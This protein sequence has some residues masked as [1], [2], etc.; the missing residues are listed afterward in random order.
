MISGRLPVI[1]CNGGCNYSP[2]SRPLCPAPRLQLDPGCDT[3]PQLGRQQS[4]T[5]FPAI[6]DTEA[7]SS[8]SANKEE[9]RAPSDRSAVPHWKIRRQW[10]VISALNLR[11]AREIAILIAVLTVNY[12]RKIKSGTYAYISRARLSNFGHVHS[13]RREFHFSSSRSSCSIKLTVLLI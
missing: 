4:R 6:N 7:R 1:V 3:I 9:D 10:R 12:H 5:I 8:P 2:L 13:E 11:R